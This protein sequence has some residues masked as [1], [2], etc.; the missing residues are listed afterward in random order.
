MSITPYSSCK[1]LRNNT[2]RTLAAIPVI[3]KRKG[4]FVSKLHQ[5]L[6]CVHRWVPNP[7]FAKQNYLSVIQS[8]RAFLVAWAELSDSLQLQ[9]EAGP[10]F[11][12]T[13]SQL[14][15]PSVWHLS[16]RQAQIVFYD[17]CHSLYDQNRSPAAFN[18]KIGVLAHLLLC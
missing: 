5:P 6:E 3:F 8:L 13:G 16:S 18:C 12:R 15:E 17:G 11:S 10:F 7:H 14:V 2:C 9:A 1:R 4:L